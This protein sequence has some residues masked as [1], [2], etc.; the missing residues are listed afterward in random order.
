MY[1]LLC[2][3]PMDT[4]YVYSYQFAFL[5]TEYDNYPDDTQIIEIG[6]ESYGFETNI[7]NISFTPENVVALPGGFVPYPPVTVVAGGKQQEDGTVFNPLWSFDSSWF[8]I[9]NY[10]ASSPTFSRALVYLQISRQSTGIT[11]R[12][13]L[14]IMLLLLLGKIVPS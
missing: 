11:Y 13:A 12:L 7:I 4:Y 5:Y 2:F 1:T 9:L 8:T 14:P 10:N 3:K 6:I